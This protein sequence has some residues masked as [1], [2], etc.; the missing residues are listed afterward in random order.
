MLTEGDDSAASGVLI[1][2]AL[3]LKARGEPLWPESSLT[4]E[5]LA[6][7]YPPEGWRVAWRGGVAVACLCLLDTDPLFWPDDGPGEALYLHKLAVHPDARG[8]GFSAW[9]MREAVRETRERGRL[10]LKLDTATARPK[11]RA[12]YETFGFQNVGQRTVKGFD[13]TLYGLPT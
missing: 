12:I 10:W 13:V 6:R 2:A 3:H 5:R 4:P 7:Y 11:L 9:L 1:A 8:Q